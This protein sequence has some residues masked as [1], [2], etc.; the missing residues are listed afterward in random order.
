MGN[1]SLILFGLSAFAVGEPVFHE[2]YRPGVN[3]LP[4]PLDSSKKL[5]SLTVRA[6][7]N[8]VVIG[9]MGATLAK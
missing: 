5:K 1:P 6:R 4:M 9:L 8:E 2:P 3:K 7:D